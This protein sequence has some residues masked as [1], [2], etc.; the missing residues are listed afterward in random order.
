MSFPYSSQ[1]DALDRDVFNAQDTFIANQYIDFALPASVQAPQ[2]PTEWQPFPRPESSL[3]LLQWDVT[4]SI[5]LNVGTS[6]PHNNNPMFFGHAATSTFGELPANAQSEG[7]S[8]YTAQY[9][10]TFTSNASWYPAPPPQTMGRRMFQEPEITAPAYPWAPAESQ[11]IHVPPGREP[12]TGDMWFT[13]ERRAKLQEALRKPQHRSPLPYPRS[14]SAGFQ[15]SPETHPQGEMSTQY[16][17]PVVDGGRP[18]SFED[19]LPVTMSGSAAYNLDRHDMAADIPIDSRMSMTG[20]NLVSPHPPI[21]NIEGYHLDTSSDLR[22]LM[23][24]APTNESSGGRELSHRTRY[25]EPIPAIILAPMKESIPERTVSTSSG[26]R[27][28]TRETVE[29]YLAARASKMRSS[30]E[31]IENEDSQATPRQRQAT[32][33]TGEE[34]GEATQ[35]EAAKIKSLT[36]WG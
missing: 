16:Q 35:E 32:D 25:I 18:E 26:I 6:Y 2:A 10:H 19:I 27:Y 20:H 34:R 5:P 17:R 36:R 29:I 14:H 22:V 23:A 33:P 28:S 4:P 8:E 21:S 7:T 11:N 24:C 3:P 1:H 30:D 9:A 13:S 31:V 15:I 12:A